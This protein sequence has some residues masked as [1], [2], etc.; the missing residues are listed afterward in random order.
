MLHKAQEK[1]KILER[2]IGKPEKILHEKNAEYKV[3]RI[4]KD[5]VD[6]VIKTVGH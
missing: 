2:F 1:Q 6:Q 3:H 4:K 5:Q